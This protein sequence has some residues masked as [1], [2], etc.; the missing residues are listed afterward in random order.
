M[1]Y[2]WD[3]CFLFLFFLNEHLDVCPYDMISYLLL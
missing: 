1:D 3:A 2:Y